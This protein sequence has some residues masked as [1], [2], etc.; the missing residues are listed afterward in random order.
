MS[1]TWDDAAALA[2]AYDRLLSG[3]TVG[4]AVRKPIRSSWQ[5]CRLR[6]IAA[7]GFEVPYESALDVEGKLA[8]AAGPVLDRLESVLSGIP[9]T[10]FL[11]DEQARIMERRGGEPSLNRY[12]H[13]LQIAPGFG[14]PEELVGTNGIGTALAVAGP[15]IVV[16]REHFADVWR[17]LAC[18]GAPIRDPLS[19]Q[20]L[21]VLDLTCRDRDSDVAMLKAVTEAAHGIEQRLLDGVTARERALLDAYQGASGP[22]GRRAA[23]QPSGMS[24]TPW[25]FLDL[26]DRL[27][28]EER[29]TELI[30]SG[31]AG[32]A[33]VRLSHGR[34]AILVSRPVGSPSGVTGLAVEA[35][36]P[37]VGVHPLRSRQPAESPE[38][39]PPGTASLMAHGHLSGRPLPTAPSAA[40]ADRWLLAVGEPVIGRLALRARQRLGLI[41]DAG[42]R[43]GT[44]LDVS[45]TAEELTE[46]A[47]PRFADFAAV[48]LPDSV[49][50]GE[51]P[52]RVDG[53]LRRAAMGGAYEASHLHGLGDLIAF[54]PSTPQAQ[55]LVTGEPVRER[56]L[57]R[58][59]GWM[60]HDPVRGSKIL[61]AGVHSLIA[62]PMLARDTV[63]GV[64]SF[65]RSRAHGP[66]EED[67][68]ILAAE[69]VGHA[70]VCI[71]NARRF[72]REHAMALTLQKSMLPSG[73]P[74]QHAVEAAH[75]YL[76]AASGVGGDWFDVIPLSGAR[77]A[78]VVGDVVGHGLHAA[79]T[80]GRLRTA[81]H[82]FSALDLA[83]DEI[84]TQLDDLV[85]RLDLDDQR[86]GKSSMGI[87]GTSCLYAVYDP[88]TRRCTLGRAGHLP[89]AMVLPDGTV[90]F[91][92]VPAGPPLGLGGLPFETVDAEL[93]EGSLL[94]LY[95]DGLIEHL[96]GGDLEHGLDRLRSVLAARGRTP[97]QVCKAL[98]ALI[99]AE[100]SDDIA[101]LVARTR[102]L[103][104]G[105]L[106]TWDLPA[107]PSVVSRVREDV[108][109]RLTGWGLG[110]LAFTTELVVSELVTN[111]IRYGCEPIQ[112]RL[113]HD[114]T[115]IC[116]VSDGSSIAPRMRRALTL[117][118]GGRGLFLVAQL[119]QRWGTRYTTQ[120]KV[121][122]VELSLPGQPV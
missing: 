58:A 55:A 6:G 95:T 36:F 112:L 56:T 51:E 77:V 52:I 66:F 84:L 122:W 101:L 97:E 88:S 5:R 76:P 74:V 117:D 86:A 48:D 29:A 33:E 80:M 100:P 65:Y 23:G 103:G 35:A 107:D 37:G 87:V 90:E 27:V 108:I 47:V 91:P 30:S 24:L 99:P 32:L 14:I 1:S 40:P 4:A 72:T 81:V 70:A 50:L 83:A 18:A 11:T 82:N 13:R 60:A 19:G 26:R 2:E 110:E 42:S 31:Q 20:F 75:R 114:S 10:M 44:T 121:I 9:V 39:Q 45:R 94:V 93:P 25:D 106:A 46:V 54:A 89:P 69:L 92:D 120:G 34:A 43:I 119:T 118:E 85:I 57:S 53:P 59:P 41:A 22:S 98:G 109:A 3:R 8:H 17:T 28:L 79:A 68:L 71:D 15:T 113:L 105:Q 12:L 115:L 116:E 102:A 62:V 7:D 38:P 111:A 61:G 78:L 104:A 96:G 63:L 64:V 16:G 67:D 73:L 21:G 49:L